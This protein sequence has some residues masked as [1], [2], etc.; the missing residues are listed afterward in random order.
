MPHTFD[1]NIGLPSI[2]LFCILAK[3]Y[4]G[5]PCKWTNEPVNF[6]EENYETSTS[7]DGPEVAS[8][9]HVELF[10]KEVG[11]KQNLAD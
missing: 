6:D 11:M 4:S 10:N 7:M 2:L 5:C 1:K 8:C 3:I 9:D